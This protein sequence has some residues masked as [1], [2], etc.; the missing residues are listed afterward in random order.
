NLH[1]HYIIEVIDF[2][3]KVDDKIEED[4]QLLDYIQD[5]VNEIVSITEELIKYYKFNGLI[6]SKMNGIQVLLG[7]DSKKLMNDK[8]NKFNKALDKELLTKFENMEFKIGVGRC[9]K[10]L[11]NVN[12]S[13]GDALKA[14][15]TGRVLTEKNVITFDELGIFKILSQDYL[16]EELED[17]YNETLK[18]LTDYDEKKSTELVKTLETYFEYNGNLKRMS[19]S[20]FTHYNTVLYRI[21]RIKDITNMDLDDPNDRL[22]L[23]I[24]LKI[25]EL[26]IM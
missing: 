5:N 20:L 7:C 14:V 8:L 2:K 9:Y 19:E 1:D 25:K 26:L 17:F 23:E 12:K 3:F 4:S 6:A 11:G 18:P 21:N 15:R 10:E 24:A 22:N 16:N 13:F